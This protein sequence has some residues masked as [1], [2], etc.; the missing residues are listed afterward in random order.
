M[1]RNCLLNIFKLLIKLSNQVSLDLNGV[2]NLML[3]VSWVGVVKEV[4]MSC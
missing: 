3:T 2:V 1:R 4:V